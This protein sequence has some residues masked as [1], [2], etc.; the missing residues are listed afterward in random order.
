MLET[1]LD[2]VTDTTEPVEEYIRHL[3][4]KHQTAK[5]PDLVLPI[6]E[7]TERYEGLLQAA[8]RHFT[9]IAD[10]TLTVSY[11][12]EWLLDNFYV[13]QQAMDLIKEDIPPQF[14]QKLPKLS[15]TPFAGYPRIYALAREMLMWTASPLTLDYIKQVI[16]IYQKITPLTVGELWALPA[17]LRVVNLENLN[18]SIGQ[19]AELPVDPSMFPASQ[20]PEQTAD[21]TLVANSVINLRVL[22]V[23]DWKAYF[24]SVSHVEHILRQ[25]PAKIYA[26]MDFETRNHYRQVIE[27]LAPE[28][29]AVEESIA[30]MAIDMASK[31]AKMCAPQDRTCHVGYYLLDDGRQDLE[32]QIGFQP[33]PRLRFR[34]WTKERPLAVYLS[35]ILLM[36]VLVLLFTAAYLIQNQ[37][38]LLQEIF[39]LLLVL[40]P[41]SGIAVQLVNWLISN[42]VPPT[43]LPKMDFSE[44]VPA[45]NCT[46]VVIPALVSSIEEVDSLIQQ[47]ELHLLRN[48]DSNLLFALLGD[49]GDAPQQ[50]MPEDDILRDHARKCIQELN[51][52]YKHEARKPFY[53]LMRERRWNPSENIWMGWE[54]KRGKLQEFNQLIINPGAET[55]YTIQDG[56]LAL[57]PKVR[58][59]ITL[60]ADTILPKDDAKRLIATLAHPLNRP[61]FDARTNTVVKGY[62]VLQ[63]RVD[64]VA[65]SAG[66]TLFTRIFAGD[67]SL[68]LYTHAVSDVYQDWFGEGSYIGKGI[69][70]VATFE[71]S[72]SGRTPD[73]KLLSHDLFEGLHVRVALVTDIVLLEDYPTHYLV[74]LRRLHRWIRGD[75]QLL[76]WL[77]PHV[78]NEGGGQVPNYLPALG[79][80]KIFDNLRRSLFTPGLFSLL[81]AGWLFLP[82]SPWFWTMLVLLAS[83]IPFI[84]TVLNMLRHVTRE[85]NW[86]AFLQQITL[87]AQRWILSLVFLAHEALLN[88]DAII[89]TLRRLIEHKH[90]LQWVT[91][92]HTARLFGHEQTPGTIFR[93]MYLS[94]VVTS[95][96]TILLIGYR[97]SELAIAVPFLLLWYAAPVIA[98]YLSLPI[99]QPAQALSPAQFEK[100]RKLARRTW[101]FFEEYVGPADNWL[102]PDHYQESPGNIIA[103]HT[104]PTNIGLTLLSTLSAYDLGYI[105]LLELSARLDLTFETFAKLDRYRGHFLNWYDTQTL[106]P[107]SPRYISA[108][109]SGNLAGCLVAL[110]QGLQ[111]LDDVPIM[112]AQRWQGLLDTLSILAEIL[113]GIKTADSNISTQEWLES[114]SNIRQQILIAESEPTARTNFVDKL[115]QE[116]WP[117]FTQHLLN[118]L[119]AEHDALDVVRI[120]ELRIYLERI[121]HHL[122]NM[123]R[124]ADILL[125]W[126]SILSE[127]P[128]L[129][130]DRQTDSRILDL[131]D[132]L[133]HLLQPV[134]ELG[135]THAAYRDAKI[136]LDEIGALLSVKDSETAAWCKQFT[137]A[138]D[139]AQQAAASL[140]ADFEQINQQIDAFIE[141]MDFTFLFDEDRKVFHIGYNMDSDRLDNSYYDL[142]ASEARITSLLAIAWDKVPQEHWLHLS[143][144]MG[145]VAGMNTLLSWS[146]TMFEYLMP[147]LLMRDYPNT[148]LSQS[149]QSVVNAQIAYCRGRNVPWG[150]SESGYYAFDGNSNYQYRAFGVPDIAFKRGMAADLVIAPY[151]SLIALPIKAGAV[152]ENYQQLEQIGALGAYGLYEAVD[153]TPNRLPIAQKFALVREYMAHHQ[154]M[155]LLSVANYLQDDVMVQRFHAD[156]RIQSVELLLQEQIP[157]QVELRDSSPENSDWVRA[158]QP[159]LNTAPWH[160]P[161]VAPVPQVHTL[162]NGHFTSLFTSAGGGYTQLDNIALTRW[163]ADTTLENWGMWFYLRDQESTDLWSITYQPVTRSDGDHQVL[164]YPHK[165]EF[166]RRH[167]NIAAQMEVTIPPDDNLEVRRIRITNQSSDSRRLFI[168]SYGEVILASHDTDQRHQAFNK[169]FIESEFVQEVNAL[170]FRRRPRSVQEPPVYLLHMLVVENDQM[171]TVAY[172]TDR[173]QFLG[174]HRTALSPAALSGKT[175]QYTQ[176]TGATL[177]PI[178]ALGQEINLEPHATA[179]VAYITIAADSRAKVLSLAHAYQLSTTIDPAFDHARYQSELELRR[180]DLNTPQ[181]EI[182]QKLLSALLYPQP[183]LRAAADI[184]ARNTKGQSGLWAYGVSGDYPIIV[185]RIS[186]ETE[187]SL[188]KDAIQAH[189][190][191]RNQQIKITLVILNQRD[192]GYTQELYTQTHRLIAHMGSETWINR[193]DGIFL[194]RADLLNDADRNLLMAS[195]RVLLDGQSGTLAQQVEKANQPPV[196]LPAFMPALVNTEPTESTPELARPNNLQFDNGYGGFSPDGREYVIYQTSGQAT[197]APWIN[198]IANPNFGFTVSES[199]A[200]FTW[201]GNSSENRLTAWRNDPVTDMASE[202]IYLR[203]E[204]TAQVWSPMPMPIKDDLPYL[205]RHGAG[206]SIFEHDSHGLKQQTTLFTAQDAPVK[207][208]RLRLENTWNRS[209][210]ITLSYYAEWV[211]G[212]RRDITQQYIIPEYQSDSQTL[213]AHNPY[214]MEFSDSYMFVSANQNFHGMTTDR[215]EFLGRLGAYASPAALKRIGL[216][217]TVQAG[218]DTCAAVQLH[219]DLQPNAVEEVFFIVGSGENR[220][221]ALELARQFR[222]P[223][224][225]QAEW[226]RVTEFWRDTLNSIEVQTPD[227]AMNLLLPWLLYQSLSCRIWGRSALYQSS[228]AFGFRDQLQDVMSVLYSHPEIARE[229][230]LRAAGYQF[231][232]GDV[233]HWWHPPSGRGV[234]TR[235]SDDLL[236]LPFVTAHYVKTSGDESILSEKIPFLKGDPLKPEEEERYGYYEP[237]DERYTLYE[238][239]RRALNKGTTAG[240]H[241]L[242]LMGAGDWNDGM[243]RVG[244]EGKGESVWMGW[245]LHTTTSAFLDL[246]KRVGDDSQSADYQLRLSELQAALE[247]NTWDG[248]WYRRAYFDDGTLLG[249]A[250]NEECKIDSIAQSWSVISQAGDPSRAKQAMQSVMNM[251]VKP[252]DA[253]LLL[254]TPPFDKTTRDPGYIKG[255][256]PGIRENGGQYTHAAIWAVWALAQLGQGDNAEAAFRLLNPIYHADTPENAAHYRVEPYVIAADIYGWPPHIGRGGWTWYTGS[257][258]WMYR[259]G[260]EMIL[261][262][263]LEGDK[264]HIDPCIPKSWPGFSIVYRIKGS[265]YRIQVSNEQSVNR[266][267]QQI[268]LDGHVLEAQ[269]VPLQPN[270]GE[271]EVTISMGL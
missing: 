83:S 225:V 111:H 28:N 230:I 181:I 125:P 237:T 185:V 201:A 8:Y 121:R 33:N 25:D 208:I 233:L 103:H 71:R 80:W 209:R 73:N 14:Y 67:T 17:M 206:Y 3:A 89:S 11:A 169:M 78:P 18:W 145:L 119:E 244:I 199:G 109:D 101:L 182:F 171:E 42:N 170:L 243:N 74:H 200:G 142:M 180:L 205:V 38:S 155:I 58:F 77:F 173:A 81:I 227:P 207:I 221:S 179:Q 139:A 161:V 150:I 190:Y 148:L 188:V 144:P 26:K 41:A 43:V 214:S 10:Q 154:G 72:L 136:A 84:T 153:Y 47:L 118:F 228:G 231:E 87:D 249:S 218:M 247:Q 163:C 162:S 232:A 24:E 45:E 245:F 62:G 9:H 120:R 91:A 168:S 210:R 63:P 193:H 137:G 7:K 270:S 192:T 189:M 2:A 241:G 134:P 100:L 102:P 223:D 216:S 159:Q 27:E 98:R 191:W 239:C 96:V 79:R 260:V 29:G 252:D 48:N 82:G 49:Y 226:R 138:L 23:Q 110:R 59:V 51:A 53:L 242:P 6:L 128:A 133:T 240:V 186:D 220:E 1:K 202:A 34:R 217:G 116:F 54:R 30:Q 36:T 143:R 104:S 236:W 4:T 152:L 211:L 213:L 68:D 198:V 158:E 250:Q 132:Q 157:K 196:Y 262:L 151:A 94:L 93:Q 44:G 261:G 255:Y 166:H 140:R 177:D 224:S 165:V 271:H 147:R 194:L 212:T 267:V 146:G 204:E 105:G 265:T 238:H 263:H 264:L 258:A 114:F 184:L 15:G 141:G 251:L 76:P 215:T 88:L 66:V 253:L 203:D 50:H 164:F 40:L 135:Q 229:H 22:A 234:R 268:T 99:E 130:R 131:W 37:A 167:Q 149:Y 115:L 117:E 197:P 70:D 183:G 61:I 127:P 35:S 235:F 55:S 52:K 39:A 266:G 12:G 5:G 31:A 56:D 21:E 178:L 113:A 172:E 123:K 92:A 65:T 13:V 219:V 122:E 57:L 176:T 64:I 195:A 246:S 95:I 160:V 174:R 112:R 16:S 175:V 129:F 107:L 124:D 222:Q 60:D 97:L 19:L 269:Y 32:A 90:L 106:K 259:L 86:H 75:W 20:L 187:L 156:P 257:A 69:Y 248:A 46:I 254:F 126:L 108:V 256:P 85:T